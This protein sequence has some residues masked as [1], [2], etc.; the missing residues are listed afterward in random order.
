[1]TLAV[2]ARSP[3]GDEAI[4]AARVA[5]E[6]LAARAITFYIC[7]SRLSAPESSALPGA[8]SMLMLFTTP[9][10]ITMQ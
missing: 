6:C 10:S 8:S 5:L 2:I 9:S 7:F 4:Q 1:M 3:K